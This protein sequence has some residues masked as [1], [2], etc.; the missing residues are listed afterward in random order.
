M[1]N[2]I[3]RLFTILFF[4]LFLSSDCIAQETSNYAVWYDVKRVYPTPTVQRDTL[5][6]AITIKDINKYYKPIW[7]REFISVEITTMIDG[8]PRTAKSKSDVLTSDQKYNMN[9]ADAGSEIYV[10]VHYI[11]ENNLKINE[12][13]VFD[14]SFHIDADVEACYPE[15]RKPLLAYIGEKAISKI[16]NDLFEGKYNLAAVKFAIDAHGQ[17]VN[18]HIFETSED[19][20]VDSL[21]LETVCNMPTWK[22]AEYANG[23]KVQ[24][25]F[26][27]TVGN[28]E[29]CTMN[30]LYVKK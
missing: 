7:I 27:L 20:R 22:S 4:G 12:P 26:V 11:P 6:E 18:P 28:Q 21:L 14:F 3:C 2:T 19:T 16:D 9:A 10:T 1:N 15:G 17:I 13:K 23:M 8:V 30:L 5:I 29:S 24:Q 25:E